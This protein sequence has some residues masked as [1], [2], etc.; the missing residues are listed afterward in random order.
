[1]SSFW[2][3]SLDMPS[4]F[5]LLTELPDSVRVCVRARVCKWDNWFPPTAAD[6]INPTHSPSRSPLRQ[7]FSRIGWAGAAEPLSKKSLTPQKTSSQL[8]LWR[9]TRI[10]NVRQTAEFS[11]VLK[12]SW[13]IINLQSSIYSIW[14]LG[15]EVLQNLGR[16][17]LIQQY[18]PH[19]QLWC[20]HLQHCWSSDFNLVKL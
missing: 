17:E 5:T 8:L 2:C 13:W 4:V 19:I 7:L 10:I 15:P 18:K 14:G 9:Q 1:M 11:S 6:W 3:S 16:S 20:K 12:F